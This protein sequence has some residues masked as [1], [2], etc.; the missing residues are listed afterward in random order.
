MATAGTAMGRMLTR[1]EARM[2]AEEVWKLMASAQGPKAEEEWLT[3]DEAASYMK[4]SKWTIYHRMEQLPHTKRNGRVMF[5]K[6]G[7]SGWLRRD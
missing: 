5:T 6:A 3:V 7:L 2:I 4:C 1:R